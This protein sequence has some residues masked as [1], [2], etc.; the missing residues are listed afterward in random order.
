MKQNITNKAKLNHYFFSLILLIFC[1]NISFSQTITKQYEE[2]ISV[3]AGS[4]IFIEGPGNLPFQSEGKLKVNTLNGY[5][6]EPR[7]NEGVAAF[8]AKKLDIKTSNN[9]ML[10]QVVTVKVIPHEKSKN[11]AKALVEAIKLNILKEGNQY[12][13]DNNFNIQRLSFKNGFFQGTKNIVILDDGSTFNVRSIEISAILLVPDDVTLSVTSKYIDVAIENFGGIIDINA[14]KSIVRLNNV[15]KLNGRFNSC[16]VNFNSIDNANII[17]YN[18]TIN[19]NSVNLLDLG[20]EV[21]VLKESLFENTKKASLSTYKISTVERLNIIETSNDEFKIEEVGSIDVK[22][23]HFSNYE[24]KRLKKELFIKAK[25]GN[26]TIDIISKDVTKLEIDNQISTINLG[27]QELDSYL[28]NFPKLVYSEKTIPTDAK[29]VT[30][31]EG[32]AFSKGITKGNGLISISCK[33]CKIDI[34]D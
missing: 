6:L 27:V 9:N 19:G 12:R 22:S 11:D 34:K 15:N 10:K 8:V 14:D 4:R 30:Q 32:I 16:K 26:I 5:A 7:D 33:N 23:S 2:E 28:I 18:S 17:A 21:I 1:V 20:T 31:G 24:I 3:S 13:I 29:K 25:N